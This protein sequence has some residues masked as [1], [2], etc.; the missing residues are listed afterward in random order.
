MKNKKNK[1]NSPNRLKCQITG[2]TR[3]S[4]A[5]Y[6][7]DKAYKHQTTSNV[8]ASF[9]VSKPA[10]KELVA[11]ISENGF[12]SAC[13]KYEVDN[14]RLKKWLRFNGRGAFVKIANNIEKEL[15]E[16]AA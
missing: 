15:S 13:E 11:F 2:A 14:D 1:K 12:A 7:S 3:M 5:T 8:W 16:L 9:Y 10:Y 6:I 4:N